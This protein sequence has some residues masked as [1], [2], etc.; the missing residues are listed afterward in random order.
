VIRQP[1]V[2]DAMTPGPWILPGSRRVLCVI[3]LIGAGR[4]IECCRTI[5]ERRCHERD[6]PSATTWFSA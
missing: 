6:H 1:D 4:S 3:F 5:R 2:L